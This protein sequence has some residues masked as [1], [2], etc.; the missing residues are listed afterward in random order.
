MDN[1]YTG[2]HTGR[3][4]IHTDIRT[5]NTE[6]PEQKYRPA[7]PAAILFCCYTEVNKSSTF[8]S[9]SVYNMCHI[10]S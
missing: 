7:S 8:F 3:D 9:S 5:C 10:G 1:C 2:D 6:E 4:N